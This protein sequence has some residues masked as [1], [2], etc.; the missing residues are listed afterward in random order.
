MNFKQN[1]QITTCNLEQ[2]LYVSS[3][4]LLLVIP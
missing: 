2:K 3:D 4:N 1:T